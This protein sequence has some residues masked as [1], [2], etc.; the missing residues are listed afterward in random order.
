MSR[1]SGPPRG[2]QQP[3]AG[4]VE[5]VPWSVPVTVD[6]IPETGLHRDIE[7]PETARAAIA[8]LSDLRDV[9]ALGASFDLERR[10]NEI[11]VTGRLRARVGQTCVVSLEPMETAIDEAINL[12]FASPAARAGV[13]AD[14]G[15]SDARQPL[16][17]DAPEPLPGNT[18]DLGAIASEFLVLAIDPYPRKEGAE[19][20]APAV[21]E[22]GTKPFAALAALQKEPGKRNN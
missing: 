8:A 2:P 5:V 12:T 18:I 21:E 1:K 22:T 17:E 4:I 9:P 13:G 10:G 20:A 11:H 19:F 16:D 6:Q 15:G 14:E 7:A 3:V